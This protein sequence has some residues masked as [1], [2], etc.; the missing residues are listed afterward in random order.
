MI[1]IVS[2]V[3]MI[4]N[5]P[6]NDAHAIGFGNV[7][8]IKAHAKPTS[9]SVII[10]YVGLDRLQFGHFC[11]KKIPTIGSRALVGNLVSQ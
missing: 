4:I 2:N 6:M 10:E 9:I 8:Q 3:V 1:A 5:D 7:N 11:I